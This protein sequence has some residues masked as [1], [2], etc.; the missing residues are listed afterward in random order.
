VQTI[1]SK[2]VTANN[3]LQ[4][5]S[6]QGNSPLEQFTANNSPQ[7]QGDSRIHRPEFELFKQ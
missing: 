3:S 6:Q 5:K 7:K 4:G 1:H 2:Q